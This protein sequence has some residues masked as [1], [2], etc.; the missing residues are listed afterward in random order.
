[1]MSRRPDEGKR[2]FVV[3]VDD[4]T[5]RIERHQQRGE[6]FRNLP[7]RLLFR[8]NRGDRRPICTMPLHN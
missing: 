8:R 3:S 4:K 7:K 5:C 6:R 1:M 2:V